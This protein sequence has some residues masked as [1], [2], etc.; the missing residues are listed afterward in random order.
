M[1]VNSI[2]KPSLD[3]WMYWTQV[4][5][6]RLTT[7]AHVYGNPPHPDVFMAE[8][9]RRKKQTDTLDIMAQLHQL[10]DA[11]ELGMPKNPEEVALHENALTDGL[12]SLFKK[13][14]AFLPQASIDM[15]KLL[16]SPWVD[17]CAGKLANLLFRGP[18]NKEREGIGSGYAEHGRLPGVIEDLLDRESSGMARAPREEKPRHAEPLM[19]REALAKLWSK[20]NGAFL[21]SAGRV[22]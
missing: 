10:T 17:N 13:V 15:Q 3:E 22:D 5:V 11:W 19:R 16:K 20:R 12:Q 14:L 8:K 2:V 4:V 7:V 18:A 1:T 21:R 9:E 6:D